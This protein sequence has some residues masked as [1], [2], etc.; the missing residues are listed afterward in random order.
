MINW[1]D[2]RR[3]RTGLVVLVV[4]IVVAFPMENYAPG[5]VSLLYIIALA[6]AFISG[7]VWSIRNV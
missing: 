3:V 5:W 4:A 7:F 1:I 6:V 2:E